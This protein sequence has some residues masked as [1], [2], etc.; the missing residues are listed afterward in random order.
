VISR[1]TSGGAMPIGSRALLALSVLPRGGSCRASAIQES[2]EP[3]AQCRSGYRHRARALGRARSPQCH[4]QP[5]EREVRHARQDHQDGRS[6][7]RGTQVTIAPLLS[8][9]GLR[10]LDQHHS[11]VRRLRADT[12]ERGGWPRGW[13]REQSGALASRHGQHETRMNMR[14]SCDGPAWTRT[15]DLPIMSRQL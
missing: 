3:R 15:R 1:S 7:H 8:V 6:S 2:Q 11:A 5:T 10:L 9:S 13:P 4:T 12:A 14:V